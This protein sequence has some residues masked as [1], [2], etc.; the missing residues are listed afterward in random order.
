MRL[1]GEKYQWRNISNQCVRLAASSIRKWAAMAGHACLSLSPLSKYLAL[2]HLSALSTLPCCSLLSF[3]VRTTMPMLIHS[4]LCWRDFHL[5]RTPAHL[6][7][8]P[9]RLTHYHHHT[10]HHTTMPPLHAHAH[11]VDRHKK[12]V[13]ATMANSHGLGGD[14][15]HALLSRTLTWQWQRT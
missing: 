12:T 7:H 10:C 14:F 5:H 3:L 4:S 6:T 11:T 2:Q 13:T 15:G 1:N 9:G 8:L